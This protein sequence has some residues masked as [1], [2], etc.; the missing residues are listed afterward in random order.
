MT[1]S[2]LTGC[3][4]ILDRFSLSAERVSGYRCIRTNM[5]VVTHVVVY[6]AGLG[7]K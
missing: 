6:P 4:S 7:I 2:L 1:H 5:G 3:F